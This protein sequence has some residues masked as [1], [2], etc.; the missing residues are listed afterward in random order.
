M[1]NRNSK[2]MF[3][4][5]AF[6]L[7]TISNDGYSVIVGGICPEGKKKEAIRAYSAISKIKLGQSKDEFLVDYIL[8]NAITQL[9]PEWINIVGASIRIHGVQKSTG[10]IIGNPFEEHESA[11]G[12]MEEVMPGL[13]L[14][15]LAGGP[16][17]AFAGTYDD[18]IL[19]E[20][21]IREKNMAQN[22]KIEGILKRLDEITKLYIL[23]ADGSGEESFGGIFISD[24]NGKKCEKFK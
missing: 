8:A 17:I 16:G 18:A 10:G 3:H 15:S 4:G 7:K 11:K 1:E 21:I 23:V 6:L 19:L 2:N 24:K 20:K 14:I 12:N 9:S 22:R 13:F 5:E